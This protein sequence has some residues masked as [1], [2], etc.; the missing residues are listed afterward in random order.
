MVE[1]RA[2][3]ITFFFL[4][5]GGTCVGRLLSGL[6]LE[7]FQTIALSF[8]DIRTNYGGLSRSGAQLLVDHKD[9][10]DVVARSWYR[11]RP[12]EWMAVRLSAKL[13]ALK[14]DLKAW[15]MQAFDVL[16]GRISSHVDVLRLLD[17]KEEDG[18]L[19]PEDLEARFQ[20]FHD[21][22]LF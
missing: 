11:S 18:P 3:L 12:M 8:S 5:G 19:L 22:W 16:D 6:F 15:H 13:E 10:R 14:V 4:M 1:R 7:M 9:F 2:G 20:G 17:L 21:L